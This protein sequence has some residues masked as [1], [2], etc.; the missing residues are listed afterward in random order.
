[1]E[2][3]AE[4]LV[5]EPVA[6]VEQTIEATAESEQETQ[7]TEPP[8]ES[9]LPD[10]FAGKSAEDIA[11]SYLELE[12]SYGRQGQEIGELRKWTDQL[13][14]ST[15]TAPS[16]ETSQAVEEE[17]DF[18]LDPAAAAQ[19]LIRKELAQALKP[20]QEQASATQAD[21]VRTQLEQNHPG[22]QETIANPKFE[23]WV[24][25]S[26]IRAEMYAKADKELHYDSINEL[27]STFNQLHPAAP[28]VDNSKALADA[29]LESSGTGQSAGKSFS[30]TKL[31]QLKIND[32][33]AYAAQQ[34][35]IDR[36]YAEGRVK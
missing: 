34:L 20:F 28:V 5:E 19:Q 1:M 27:L 35:E 11:Q 13:I 8:V 12:K 32:P 15:T 7:A 14:T 29:S 2:Q 26:P 21:K 24:L 17:I 23:N 4:I 25:D 16:I 9:T 33:Q 31:I 30:R 22:Y 10:K 18:D 36:A 3:R 6:E